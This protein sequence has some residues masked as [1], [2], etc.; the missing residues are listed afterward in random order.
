MRNV[1][2]PVVLVAVLFALVLATPATAQQPVSPTGTY[3]TEW[4]SWGEYIGP[5]T[6]SGTRTVE[7]VALNDPS[8]DAPTWAFRD[9]STG[10]EFCWA[11]ANGY[12]QCEQAEGRVL[13]Y[14]YPSD[15]DGSL[16]TR[17]FVL[18]L[19]SIGRFD[20]GSFEVGTKQLAPPPPPPGPTVTFNLTEG[21]TVSGSVAVR[22]TANGLGAGGYRWYISVDGSQVAYRV[23]STTAITWWWNTGSLAPGT[24]SLSV[25][26]LD[27][28]GTEAR[29][30]VSVR[31]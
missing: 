27:A 22:M 29:G 15:P 18:D 17:W 19:Q 28:G 24:H 5:F 13:W 6:D 21:Q 3:A 31:K 4:S 11:W 14:D 20:G 7:V 12:V 25:R 16:Q 1:I 10:S 26:V 9:P 2:A 30:S 8:P 23:E